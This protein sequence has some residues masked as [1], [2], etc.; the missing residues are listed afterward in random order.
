[1]QRTILIAVIVF[2]LFSL[3][4]FAQ[5][6]SCEELKNEIA[7][8]LDEKGVKNY[9]L[10]IVATEEIKSET[11]VGSCDGGTKRITYKRN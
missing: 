8:K 5:R 6:K 3:N 11:V 7:A 1:M 9:E 10:K 2:S 4:A